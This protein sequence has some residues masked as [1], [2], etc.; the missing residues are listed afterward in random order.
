M[1]LSLPMLIS[2]LRFVHRCAI[3]VTVGAFV[4]IVLLITVGPF[5]TIIDLKIT[6]E[7]FN[8]RAMNAALAHYVQ[9]IGTSPGREEVFSIVPNTLTNASEHR[10]TF[11]SSRDSWG[12]HYALKTT[13]DG[14]VI[15][16]YS[17]GMNGVDEM[18]HGDDVVFGRKSY[19]CEMYGVHCQAQAVLVLAFYAF[20]TA[21][22][23]LVFT[24]VVLPSRATN[25]VKRAVRESR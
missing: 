4:V 19:P 25:S 10:Y 13:F 11:R 24:T 8:V 21:F 22:V 5:S 16:I 2:A 23:L 1:S 9:L 3:V 7:L 12:N 20:A 17:L 6:S 15:E 14:K 18:G